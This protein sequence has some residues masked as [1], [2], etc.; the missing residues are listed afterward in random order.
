MATGATNWAFPSAEHASIHTGPLLAVDRWTRAQMLPEESR[1]TTLSTCTWS[2][3]RRIPTG[4]PEKDGSD[5]TTWPVAVPGCTVYRPGARSS[6]TTDEADNWPRE[7]KRYELAGTHEGKSDLP[8]VR[9]RMRG[10]ETRTTGLALTR[11]IAD[12]D[13]PPFPLP[14]AS[15][16]L[17]RFGSSWFS[18]ARL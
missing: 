5:R 2:P 10:Q 15:R 7:K 16:L 6:A 18:H 3:R 13:E 14:A 4:A 11:G 17:V 12:R 8:L 9:S 1:G